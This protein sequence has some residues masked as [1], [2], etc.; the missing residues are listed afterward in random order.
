MNFKKT[1]KQGVAV[2]TITLCSLNASAGMINVWGEIIGG[3]NSHINSFYDELSPHTSVNINGS[4]D[5]N[6]L[7][8]VDL[9]WVTS[10]ADDYT[11]AELHT[12]AD[13]LTTGGRIAFMGEHG[14]WSPA[15]NLRINTALTFL[16]SSME[17]LN[18]MLDATFHDATKVNGQILDH[19]LTAGV[20]TFNY[21]AF[22]P[23]INLSGNSES[24]MLG[25]DHNSVMMA[26][27]NVG[28]GSIFLI[29]DQNIWDNVDQSSNDNARMFENLVTANT[30]GPVASVPEPSSLAILA[31]GLI[32]LRIRRLNAN[33]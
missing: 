28:A 14:D 9:L 22:A 16:G 2:A 33:K 3:N 19:A 30:G 17:I 5:S 24:L 12:M 13:Y 21:A 15:Q 26:F 25:L 31:V 20:N 1:I 32:G 27:E 29:A 4:L 11:L 23:V 18:R 6:N 10:P 7:N 8:G